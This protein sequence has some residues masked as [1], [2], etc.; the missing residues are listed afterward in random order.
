MLSGNDAACPGRRRERSDQF[1]RTLED[2][3]AVCAAVHG[4]CGG[5]AGRA[6]LGHRPRPAGVLSYLLCVFC[7]MIPVP[8]ILLFIKK[9]LEWMKTRARLTKYA[10]W[11]EDHAQKKLDVY[12]KY[13]LLGLFILVAIPLPGTGAWTGALVASLLGVER[14]QAMLMILLG[15]AAAGAI[16]LA[17]SLGAVAV[18]G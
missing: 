14:K 13:K 16:V 17:V 1:E 4:A 10:L 11:L 8:F 18:F 6:A 15:V 5:A 12:Y 9:I 3:A 2:R 7:N